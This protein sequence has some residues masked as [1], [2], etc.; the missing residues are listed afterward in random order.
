MNSAPFPFYFTAISSK[1]TKRA[2]PKCALGI[3][4]KVLASDHSKL[5][6]YQ[7]QTD[8]RGICDCLVFQIIVSLRRDPKS[9]KLT[10][11]HPKG[12]NAQSLS[13][14]QDR[15]EEVLTADLLTE[16]ILLSPLEKTI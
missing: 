9:T 11:L 7:S 12:H 4:L 1:D 2:K 8:F 10:S 3:Q 5:Q 6:V 16:V 14:S 15:S 13:L